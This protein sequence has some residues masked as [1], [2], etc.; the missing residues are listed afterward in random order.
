[1]NRSSISMKQKQI[2]S[3]KKFFFKCFYMSKN[4]KSRIMDL[5]GTGPETPPSGLKR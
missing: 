3:R 2:I 5:G 4:T 1:M